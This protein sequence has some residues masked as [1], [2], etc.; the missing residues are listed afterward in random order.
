MNAKSLAL[1]LCLAA[2]CPQNGWSLCVSM[3]GDQENCTVG[4]QLKERLQRAISAYFEGKDAEL[5]EVASAI[6]SSSDPRFIYTAIATKAN[7]Y[8]APAEDMLEVGYP[9]RRP[10]YIGGDSR[11]VTTAK[12]LERENLVVDEREIIDAKAVD[13]YSLK[14]NPK[15]KPQ[16]YIKAYEAA[17]I[18]R[19]EFLSAVLEAVRDAARELKEREDQAKVEKT[20]KEIRERLERA[21]EASRSKGRWVY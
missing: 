10:G 8:P 4:T 20:A 3:G 19:E 12:L 21:A 18:P 7:H 5:K 2:A 16:D 13:L 9:I 6:S 11:Y 1:M 14:N 15:T 17:K